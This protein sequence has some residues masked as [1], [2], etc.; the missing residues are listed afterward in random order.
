MTSGFGFSP[1]PPLGVDEKQFV[2]LELALGAGLV[3]GDDTT[4]ERWPDLMI[5]VIRFSA[6]RKS[7]GVK[8]WATSKS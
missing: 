4:R 5:D 3:V 2:G 6:C 7:S 8:G 1:E